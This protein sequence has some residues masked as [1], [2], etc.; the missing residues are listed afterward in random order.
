VNCKV[1]VPPRLPSADSA[2]TVR[3]SAPLVGVT[4]M[5]ASPDESAV[6]VLGAAP[7]SW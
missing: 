4:V 3:V 7:L 5:V 6:T 2:V 1:A